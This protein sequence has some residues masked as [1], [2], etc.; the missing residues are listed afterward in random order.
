[1]RPTALPCGVVQNRGNGP[2]DPTV[3][4]GHDQFDADQAPDP[5]ELR[6][7]DRSLAGN[8]VE[9]DDLALALVVDG[10]GNNSGD[11]NYPARLALPLGQGV[12]LHVEVR[13]T[14]QW[15]VPERRRLGVELGGHARD[16]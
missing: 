16:L 8:D 6:P 15:P 10:G 2:F 4:V 14:V 1:M 7:T 11:V 12:D 5:E 3:G 9:A 13:A